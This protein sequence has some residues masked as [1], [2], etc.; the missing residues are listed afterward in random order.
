MWLTDFRRQHNLELYELAGLIRIV[1]AKKI[2]A[3]TV[4]EGMIWRLEIDENFRTIPK[5]ADLIAECCGA[6]AAQRDELVLKKYRGT[7]KPPKDN[8]PRLPEKREEKPRYIWGNGRAVVVI[9]QLGNEIRRHP[10]AVMAAGWVGISSDS[11]NRRCNRETNCW[12]FGIC[13]VSFRWADEYD[14]MSPEER[15]RDAARTKGG[16][17]HGTHTK[18]PGKRGRGGATYARPVTVINREGKAYFFPSVNAAAVGLRIRAKTIYENIAR[19]RPLL[20][21]RMEGMSFMYTSDYEKL[22]GK[23]SGIRN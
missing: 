7:W 20:A 19:G 6:T 23:E 18:E 22:M 12:E 9:D 15:A 21:G 11:V 3:L 16:K 2:P 5:L 10:S 14:A 1:G 13:K 8:R 4:S 17:N